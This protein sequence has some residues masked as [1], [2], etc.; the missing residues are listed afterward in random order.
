MQLVNEVIRQTILGEARLELALAAERISGK[1]GGAGGPLVGV[2]QV[3]LG[4]TSA[5]RGSHSWWPGQQ[6][7]KQEDGHDGLAGRLEELHLSL[8]G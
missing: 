8:V 1:V 2:R 6:E 7:R 3:R 5:A 4:F